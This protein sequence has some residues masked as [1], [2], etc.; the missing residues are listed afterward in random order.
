LHPLEQA[1][2]EVEG[3]QE[4]RYEVFLSDIGFCLADKGLDGAAECFIRFGKPTVGIG[5][6]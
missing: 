4:V 6:D 1:L 2:L 5:W 3:G